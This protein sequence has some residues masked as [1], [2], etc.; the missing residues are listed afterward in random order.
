MTSKCELP[1]KPQGTLAERVECRTGNRTI[2]ANVPL[3]SFRRF[4]DWVV[5]P[6]Q[7]FCQSTCSID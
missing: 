7:R 1:D 6:T 4:E 3:P 2:G 5:S